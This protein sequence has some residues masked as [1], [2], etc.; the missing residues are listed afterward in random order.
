MTAYFKKTDGS[1][2]FAIGGQ[3]HNASGYRVEDLDLAFD[4]LKVIKANSVAIPVYWEQIEPE[5]DVF[6][7]S[8]LERIIDRVREE[9]LRLAVLWFG[10]WK[11]GTM[12]YTPSWVKKQPD[13]FKRVL[14]P[15]GSPT[16]VLSCN[17]EENRKAD[18]KAF[19][20]LMSFIRDYDADEKT[21]Y[22]VQVEN[23]PGI[24]G[25]T[26]RDFSEDG[27]RAM[28]ESVPEGLLDYVEARGCGKVYDSWKA[29]GG[30]R[31]GDW[32]ATFGDDGSW[33]MQ[34]YTQACY[35]DS[36]AQAGKAIYD[37][38]MYVNVWDDHQGWDWPGVSFPSGGA[39]SS[40][41]DIYKYV[42]KAID[43]VSP[44]IYLPDAESYRERMQSFDR[45]D[46]PLYI[47]ESQCYGRSVN[48]KMAFEA[49]G[50]HA[51][52]GHHIFGVE[53]VLH[54]D[55][56]IRDD[57][58]P[59]VRTM[60][61]LSDARPLIE[62]YWDRKN[63]WTVSQNLDQPCTHIVFGNWMGLIE[64][65]QGKQLSDWRHLEWNFDD[66]YDDK[67]DE[68]ARGL[69][70]QISENEFYIVGEG[71]RVHFA[72][73]CHDGKINPILSSNMFLDRDVNYTDCTEGRFDENGN[74]V[75]DRYRDGDEND[76]GVWL[77]EDI[78]IVHVRL[79]P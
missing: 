54:N 57:C 77:R 20:K 29:A 46:N 32:E 38:V 68:P 42:C 49:V 71:F 7:F 3:V 21:I 36:I 44:D 48:V 22:A 18:E 37:V 65:D 72:P 74:Y 15:D 47:P 50:K 5:E 30:F 27:E 11:N 53:G 25:G 35:I 33:F 17:C 52:V 51:S 67:Y 63:V 23:E 19:R 59:I 41:I 60:R 14:T 62:K 34:S 55:G 39:V 16:A 79:V 12:K 1:P 69:I 26:V 56:T 9:G 4:A 45:E 31:G 73:T 75:I 28:K 78:G 10:T 40:V 8:E 6:D 70:F 66:D 13:R 58:Q 2:F 61:M 43:F 24:I 64:F 76:F